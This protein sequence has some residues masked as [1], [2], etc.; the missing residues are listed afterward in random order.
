MRSVLPLPLTSDPNPDPGDA[1]PM[2]PLPRARGGPCALW[3]LAMLGLVS[4][5][6]GRTGQP[7]GSWE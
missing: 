4:A 6:V 3:L 1:R 5:R 2:Q 7:G